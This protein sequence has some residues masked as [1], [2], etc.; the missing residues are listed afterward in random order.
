MW[1]S[2]PQFNSV[3][4]L[5]FMNY[6]KRILGIRSEEVLSENK[7]CEIDSTGQ[8]YSDITNNYESDCGSYTYSLRHVEFPQ[9][10]ENRTYYTLDVKFNREITFSN[11]KR[12]FDLFYADGRFINFNKFGYLDSENN[13]ASVDASP[14]TD[15]YYTLGDNCPLGLL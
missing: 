14:V 8:L 1:P 3:C 15:K 9:T 7:G 2:Q 13:E 11:F 5:R 4:T 6:D 10:D 12:D